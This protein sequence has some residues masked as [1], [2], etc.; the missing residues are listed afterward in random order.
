MTNNGVDHR[1][2]DAEARDVMKRNLLA[3]VEEGAERAIPSVGSLEFADEDSDEN[4]SE[5]AINARA[6][7]VTHVLEDIL[8]KSKSCPS[9]KRANRKTII[10]PRHLTKL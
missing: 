6:N 9:E 3:F 7:V 5:D 2:K 10:L 8:A 4:C 1:G